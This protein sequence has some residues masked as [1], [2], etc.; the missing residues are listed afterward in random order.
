MT[1]FVYIM[2]YEKTCTGRLHSIRIINRVFYY[3]LSSILHGETPSTKYTPGV[4]NKTTY[5][6]Q[7]YIKK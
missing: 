7:L 3:Y 2:C 1:N 5:L 4:I 6:R